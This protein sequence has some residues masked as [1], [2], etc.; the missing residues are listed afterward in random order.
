MT[1]G[2]FGRLACV[3]QP[4]IAYQDASNV[5]DLAV[6]ADSQVWTHLNTGE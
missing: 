4:E 6:V 5:F 3:S 1:L 2:L